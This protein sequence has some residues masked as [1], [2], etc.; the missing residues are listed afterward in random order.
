[1]N[2][3]KEKKCF[4]EVNSLSS[5][6]GFIDNAVNVLSIDCRVLVFFLAC[7]GLQNVESL[8]YLKTITS[9]L[10]KLI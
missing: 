9:I 5:L 7:D 6:L 8:R 10:E 4:K 1:M 3:N 2:N